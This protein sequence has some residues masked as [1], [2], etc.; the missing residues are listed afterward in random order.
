VEHFVIEPHNSINKALKFRKTLEIFVP[1]LA[2]HIFHHPHHFVQFEEVT[3]ISND[4]GL[5]Q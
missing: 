4:R 2:E 3:A 5:I 1:A